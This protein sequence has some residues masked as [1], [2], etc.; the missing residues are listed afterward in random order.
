MKLASAAVATLFVATLFAAEPCAA[1]AAPFRVT[2]T[3][4]IDPTNAA[5][6]SFV[7]EVH[8]DWAP[9]GVARFEELLGQGFFSEL[10]FFRVVKNFMVQFGI[11]GDPA[12]SKT[13]HRKTI[14][15]DPVTQTNRRGFVTFATS[16]PNSR[17]SQMFINFKDNT[18][19]DKQGFSP[20]AE[21]VE[22]MDVVDRI[23]AG[24]GE[25][26]SQGHIT[27]DGN[28]YLERDFPKLSFI[29]AAQK[30]AH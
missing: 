3:V 12:V 1:G 28:R 13:W 5:T 25:K 21:V 10:R 18:F 26:P 2:F 16:G 30:N 14:P 7:L 17:T 24:Y 6:E 20:F 29:K 27:A 22:G 23:Y 19:L 15:N 4:Q 9:N 11:S 8:P